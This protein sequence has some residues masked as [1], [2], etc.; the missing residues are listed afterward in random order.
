MKSDGLDESLLKLLSFDTL[1][2]GQQVDALVTDVVPADI[3]T[4]VS[5][6]VQVQISPFIRSSL[7]FSDILDAKQIIKESAVVDIGAFI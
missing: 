1:S 6:P 7:L 5:C 3:A 4:K 2:E